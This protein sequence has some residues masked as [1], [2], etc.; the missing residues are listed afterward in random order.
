MYLKNNMKRFIT[1]ILVLIT[2]SQIFS[3]PTD[4]SYVPRFDSG[5]YYGLCFDD[6]IK[7]KFDKYL[8]IQFLSNDGDSL[9]SIVPYRIKKNTNPSVNKK[10]YKVMNDTINKYLYYLSSSVTDIEYTDININPWTI[11]G[12]DNYSY[13]ET[14]GDSLF[15]SLNIVDIETEEIEIFY[16]NGAIK[17]KGEEIEAIVY[18]DKDTFKRGN[19]VLKYIPNEN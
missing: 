12:F 17:K 18:S 11:V 7:N 6:D 5:Y 3:Q 2:F 19:V 8:F 13:Y 15:F 14:K 16:F 9:L 4:T 10:N 1:T